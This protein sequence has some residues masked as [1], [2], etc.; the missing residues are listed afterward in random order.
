MSS[1]NAEIVCPLRFD[2]PKRW[3]LLEP[4]DT[5]TIRYCLTCQRDVHCVESAQE[6]R[7]LI[8]AGCCIAAPPE[9]L[10][11]RGRKAK[12]CDDDTI[13]LVGY[14]EELDGEQA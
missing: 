14:A 8:R 12:A 6:L 1:K 3:E 9:W 4:T 7:R 10:V 2:C 13:M 5:G 11:K